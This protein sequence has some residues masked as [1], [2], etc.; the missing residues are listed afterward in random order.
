MACARLVKPRLLR[1]KERVGIELH[2]RVCP[3]GMDL[4]TFFLFSSFFAIE[5]CVEIQVFYESFISY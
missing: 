4:I 3:Y 2:L 1:F 5:I